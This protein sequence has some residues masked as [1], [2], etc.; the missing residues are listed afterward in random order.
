MRVLVTGGTGFLGR[1][2]VRILSD[3]GHNGITCSSM[4]PKHDLRDAAYCAF[5]MESRPDVIVHLACPMGGGNVKYAGAKEADL[6]RDMLRINTNLFEATQ[7]AGIKHV[8]TIGSVCAYP[9]ANMGLFDGDCPWEPKDLWDGLPHV[10][11]RAYGLAKRMLAEQGEAYFRQYGMPVTHLILTNLYGPGD[12]LNDLSHFIPATIKKMIQSPDQVVIWGNG[13]PTRDFLYVED[14]AREIVRHVEIRENGLR[15]DRIANLC[16]ET[17]ISIA[18][19]VSLLRAQLAYSGAILWDHS[20]PNG[21]M[22]RYMKRTIDPVQMTF[23]PE[24][25]KRTIEWVK[26]ELSK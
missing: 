17:Q 3:R 5:L 18:D 1:H 20:Q 4:D 2:V 26:T 11:H 7:V 14:A 15:S 25:L 23:F 21:Q 12:K 6:L 22:H 10:S 8:I 24:G 19:V 16:T 9:D 13:A